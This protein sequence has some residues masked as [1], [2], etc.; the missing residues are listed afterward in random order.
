MRRLRKRSS[1]AN[2]VRVPSLGIPTSAVVPPQ[3]VQAMAASMAA[4]APLHSTATS[5]ATP[6]CVLTRSARTSPLSV[7]S[8]I[9]VPC[10]PN[11]A[12][13]SALAGLTSTAR[14]RAAPL[15]RAVWSTFT[16]IPPTPK[17]TTAS[18]G[19]TWATLRTTPYPVDTA[20]PI[21]AAEVAGMPGARTSWLA[22]TV[23]IPA[24]DEMWAKARTGRPRQRKGGAPATKASRH[25][26]VRPAA[27]K[28][29]VPQGTVDPTTTASPGLTEVTPS[30][31]RSTTPAASWPSTTGSGT[32]FWPSITFRSLWQIPEAS[33]RSNTSP[34]P[35]SRTSN[36]SVT[37]RSTPS[38]TAPLVWIISW[39]GG[40]SAASGG[41]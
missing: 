22:R 13:T 35:G 23:V 34:G 41:E 16:P 15:S 25:S 18:P 5:T 30:P 27:Q 31:T 26:L 37:T 32:G 20:Q 19:R 14:I 38:H 1:T 36:S 21:S 9:R 7:G 3:A 29:H 12:A 24:H 10:A 39:E 40:A 33:T 8:A 11:L 28:R 2:D 17:T 6:I 4:G